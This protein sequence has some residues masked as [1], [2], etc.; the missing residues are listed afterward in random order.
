MSFSFDIARSRISVIGAARSGLAAAHLLKSKGADVFLSE[1]SSKQN[2]DHA[3][4]ELAAL[5][6]RSEFGG[7]TE[8]VFESKLIVVSPGVP[9]ESWVLVEANKRGIP[10]IAEIELASLFCDAPIIGIT[11]TNGKTTTTTLTGKILT[12]AGRPTIIAGNIGNA[13]SDAILQSDQNVQSVVL[14]VSSFQLDHCIHFHPRIAVLTTVTPDHLNRYHGIFGE[15]MT[16]KKRIFMN[17]NPDDALIYNADNRETVE[18]VRTAQ[19]CLFPTSVEHILERGGWM[20]GRKLMINLGE[21]IETIA[22]LDELHLRGRHNYM[23][24]L[25]AALVGRMQGIP[26][27]SISKSVTNFHGVEHRLEFVRKID[28]VTWI[29]DSKATNVDSVVIALQ[30][31]HQPVVLIAGGRDKEA[32]YDPLVSLVEEK[33]RAAV[34][35]G[36][37]AERMEEAFTGYTTVYR[38]GSIPAAVDIASSLAEAGDVVLLSPACSSF[39]MFENFEHRGL[40]FKKL[41][42][43]LRAHHSR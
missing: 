9:S 27:A 38:A 22:A 4:D 37:A 36:E 11:G 7:H 23:N 5:D 24:I 35:I 2:M 16:S 28:D 14:E 3:V 34:L 19:A 18:A 10:V 43:D 15:Y 20:E 21:G 30:S 41:V 29:N 8:L 33:V 1:F 31:F 17:Q 13:F 40:L 42:H 39:D 26:M 25:M 12:E 6:I 32:P